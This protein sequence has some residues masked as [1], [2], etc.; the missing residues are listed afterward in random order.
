M[1]VHHVHAEQFQI[2]TGTHPQSNLPGN[3]VVSVVIPREVGVRT[4]KGTLSTHNPRSTS[5]TLY[6]DIVMEIV[7]IFVP[8]NRTFSS[9]LFMARNSG[10]LNKAPFFMLAFARRVEWGREEWEATRRRLFVPN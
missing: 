8:R 4:P 1:M 10:F 5:G 6:A 3:G 7:R 2:T 9:A